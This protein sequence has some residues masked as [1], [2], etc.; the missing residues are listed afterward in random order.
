[1]SLFNVSVIVWAKSQDSVH[2]PPFLKGKESQNGLNPGHSAHQHS[3][4]PLGHIGSHDGL[5]NR[6]R[7]LKQQE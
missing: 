2:K 3:A 4:L 5:M 6:K 1:M 7:E